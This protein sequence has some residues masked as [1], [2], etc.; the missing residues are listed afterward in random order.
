MIDNPNN[1][2]GITRMKRAA[3]IDMVNMLLW[4]ISA[5][6]GAVIFYKWRKGRT[7]FT[8]RAPSWSKGLSANPSC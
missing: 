7:A 6:Y 4:L 5:V 3:W 1:D 2:K 8:S